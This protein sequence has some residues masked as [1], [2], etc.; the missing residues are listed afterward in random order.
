MMKRVTMFVQLWVED[1]WVERL[2]DPSLG[3]AHTVDEAHMVVTAVL[4]RRRNADFVTRLDI[5]HEYA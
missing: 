3:P 4:R 2:R 1:R 5:M